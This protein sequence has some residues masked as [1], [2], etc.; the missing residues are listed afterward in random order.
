MANANSLNS[1]LTSLSFD[2]KKIYKEI[3]EIMKFN[4]IISVFFI[5]I[6]SSTYVSAENS[7]EN[8]HKYI[9]NLVKQ[10]ALSISCSTTFEKDYSIEKIEGNYQ[11]HETTLKQI[12]KLRNSYDEPVYYVLWGG[13]VGCNKSATGA[14]WRYYLTEVQYHDLAEKFLITKLN[15]IENVSNDDNF[16]IGTIQSISNLSDNQLEIELYEYENKDIKKDVYSGN[17]YIKK[18]AT[19]KLYKVIVEEDM[20]VEGSICSEG[21]NY[22]VIKKEK[23]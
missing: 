16:S 14:T 12:F 2:A 22:R 9:F 1:I 8:T 7:Q 4:K 5:L 3:L 18:N 6:L 15:T 11:L 13:D 23:I 20:S 21:I 17:G 10:Y 19:Q